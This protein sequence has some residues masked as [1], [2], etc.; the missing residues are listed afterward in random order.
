MKAP[1]RIASGFSY[2]IALTAVL[3]SF[4]LT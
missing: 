4:Q 1:T 3:F 2:G